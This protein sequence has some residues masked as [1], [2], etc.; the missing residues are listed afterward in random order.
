MRSKICVIGLTHTFETPVADVVGEEALPGA[1]VVI[2]GPEADVVAGARRAASR[3][4]GAAIV[5]VGGDVRAALE[6][7]LLP[8]G[9]VFAVAAGDLRDAAEAVVLDRRQTITVELVGLEDEVVRVPASVGAGG[10][11]ELRG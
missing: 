6:A 11:R 2:L 8:R 9:R 5:V 4:S 10:I 1:D 3:A 7:S